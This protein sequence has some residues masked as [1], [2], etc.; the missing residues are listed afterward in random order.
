[1]SS[2]PVI[3]VGGG[4]AGLVV[5][6]RLALAGR[7]VTVLER[8][9]VLGGQVVPLP[10]A[11]IELD[12]AA[13]SFAT[14]G[15]AVAALAD[16][17]G[18]AGDIV[19]PNPSPAWLHRADGS[20]VPL[21]AVGVLG[22]PGDPLAAD[23]VRAIGRPAA[24]RAA[25]DR[26]LPA[27]VGRDAASLGELVRVRM[28]RGVADGLVAP[29]VRGVHSREPDALAVDVASPR[30]RAEIA[31]RG[32]L[33]AA[34]RALRAQA[35][36][37]SQVAGFRGG[38]HRLVSALVADGRRHG[39]V[40]RTGVTVTEVTADG[41]VA[42]GEHLRGRV[43]R[44]T[45]EPSADPR[46]LTLV[47]L[48]VEAPA[49]DA[50]PRGT[51]LLIAAEAPGVEARALTHVSAKWQ[52]VREALPGRHVVR[53]SY[54][55]EPQD[56]VA[57]AAHDAAVLLG[58][59]IDRVTDAAVGSWSRGVRGPVDDLPSVGEGAAGTGLASVIPH[60]ERVAS[61]ILTGP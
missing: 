41:V 32:S 44:A 23:V 36:A 37:G 47:T 15:G 51:G 35:P 17:L 7:A 13:E 26:A 1:M 55:G 33:A 48:V 12:A 39:V 14:R 52:W 18:I 2:D 42:D 8:A 46:Q 4:V 16:E 6:R 3:V 50:A 21:P 27:R 38:M 60:A 9:D 54:D 40:F 57:Q 58:T 61:G 49:L 34:V 5:A 20:A 25:L 30:L 45:S 28:G 31:A 43:V 29:V 19:L 22:I 11:G 53:L 24:W 59:P 56:P 10:I